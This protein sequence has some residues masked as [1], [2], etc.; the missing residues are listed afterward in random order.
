M[1]NFEITK[2]YVEMCNGAVDLQNYYKGK[3]SSR[4]ESFVREGDFIALYRDPNKL[5]MVIVKD[6]FGELD[7]AG[8]VD[9]FDK[10]AKG[11]LS[12]FGPIHKN[13]RLDQKEFTW[14]PRQEQI[15]LLLKNLDKSLSEFTKFHILFKDILND[16]Y[17]TQSESW[18]E[19]WLKL[20]MDKK[21]GQRWSESERKWTTFRKN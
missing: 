21:Y 4:S 20:Y 12:M 5:H 11:N 7:T 1:T 8:L 14:L 9:S 16:A 3:E 19:I 2:K 6:D 15:Q 10:I 13:C 18:E 17:F